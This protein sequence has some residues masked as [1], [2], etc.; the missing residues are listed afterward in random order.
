MHRG[1]CTFSSFVSLV[2]ILEHS[3]R[4][5]VL[6]WV[7]WIWNY[8]VLSCQHIPCAD[9]HGCNVSC[10]RF[11]R[12]RV[13]SDRS[14]SCTQFCRGVGWTLLPSKLPLLSYLDG[15][16]PYYCNKLSSET[17]DV[18]SVWLNSFIKP[19]VLCVSAIPIQGWHLSTE[20][21]V[22]WDRVATPIV[23]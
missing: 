19:R 12:Q 1:W 21:M 10:C 16:Q 2:E 14:L 23:S 7:L 5:F 22:H 9:Q 15:L 18:I 17:F 4:F 8:L 3:L 11:F 6:D 13:R 20:T